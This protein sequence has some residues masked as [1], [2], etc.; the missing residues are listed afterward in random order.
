MVGKLV[1]SVT[2]TMVP[3]SDVL[4]SEAVL[5]ADERQCR[6]FFTLTMSFVLTGLV[7]KAW[8]ASEELPGPSTQPSYKSAS[9]TQ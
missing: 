5:Q 4:Y 6:Q 7:C 3:H 1:K 8:S 2:H 9:R